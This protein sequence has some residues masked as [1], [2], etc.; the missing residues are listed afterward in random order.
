VLLTVQATDDTGVVFKRLTVNGV[1]VALSQSGQA[2]F[3]PR[4]AGLYTALAEAR[5]AAG[6]MDQ[7]KTFF[8]ARTATDN[9]SPTVALTAPTDDTI[10]ETPLDLIGT[11][12]DEDLVFYELQAS[13]EGSEGFATFFQGFSSVSAG[14]LG[15]L[16]PKA[17]R[18]GSYRVCVRRG[19]VGQSCLLIGPEIRP[20]SPGASTGYRSHRFPRRV[21]RACRLSHSRSPNL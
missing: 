17:F 9:G 15:K 8:R 18:S 12:T 1:D 14:P 6:N 5:D 19:H 11:A 20:Q 13:P 3:N 21:R 7:D 2:T 16:D 10:A 4:A